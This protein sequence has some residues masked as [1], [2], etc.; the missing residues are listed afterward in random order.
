VVWLQAKIYEFEIPHIEIG[1]PVEVTVQS[2]PNQPFQGK[3][4][5]VEPVVQEATRTIKVRVAID[6]SAG[7]LKPGTYAD[8][9]IEHDMG[10]GLLVPDS[11]VM[12]TG[13]RAIC[14]RSLPEGRFEPVE[15]KLGGRFDDR[16]E[17]LSGLKEGDDI[18][19]SA[20]FLIDSESRLKATTSGAAGGH[21]HGG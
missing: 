2:E 1:Q 16:F 6:N 3:V 20:G 19:V 18:V 10:E 5:F 4:A 9:K 13:E 14:F 15:V 8:L 11:A 21:K 12:R 17:V 7:L